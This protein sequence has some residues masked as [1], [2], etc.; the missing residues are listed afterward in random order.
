MI[1]MTLLEK[2]APA[3]YSSRNQRHQQKLYYRPK[4]TL[5]EEEQEPWPAVA[6]KLNQETVHTHT[7]TVTLFFKIFLSVTSIPGISTLCP[8][9][10]LP[11]CPCPCSWLEITANQWVLEVVRGYKLELARQSTVP[12]RVIVSKKDHLLT[13]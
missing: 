13:E 7:N 2:G 3:K 10:C 12:P 1:P 4:P 9:G 5:R 6:V 8:T 11:Y